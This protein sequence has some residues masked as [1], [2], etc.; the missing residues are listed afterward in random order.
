MKKIVAFLKISFISII[1]IFVIIFLYFFISNKIFLGAKNKTNIEYLSQNKSLINDSVSEDLFDDDFYNSK[2][3]LLGEIH[4]Y[5]DNQ[6][7]DKQLFLFLNKKLGVKYYIA[8]MDSTTA[9]KLNYYLTKSKKDEA[10]L[11]DV[12]LSV[13]KRIPQQSSKELF[14]KWSEIYDYNQTLADSSKIAVLGIDI[15]FDNNNS[16]ISRDSAM[17]VNFKNAIEKMNLKNETFYGLF[18]YY[19]T[20]QKS[21][22]TDKT[23]FAEQ[24]KQSGFKTTSLVSYTLDSEMYLPENPQFP[25]PPEEKINWINADGPLML[26]KGIND[27]KALSKSNSITLFKLNSANSPYLNSQNLIKVKSKIFGE[28][29]YPLKNSHTTDYFQYVFLLRNSKALTKL[30]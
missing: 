20:L 8:E 7:L 18:G 14:D 21:P 27:L 22:I 9:Q 3:F 2:V 10:L 11:R 30:K 5:A 26:V 28:S 15:D 29:I 19:H 4:G 1:T 23:T 12:V 17:M 16:K 13:K 6:K 25:T 24:L